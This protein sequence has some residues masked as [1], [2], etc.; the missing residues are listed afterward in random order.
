MIRWRVEA[1][2]PDGTSAKQPPHRLPRD[3]PEYHGTVVV[4]PAIDTNLPVLHWFVERPTRADTRN[5]TLAS[6]FHRGRFYDNIFCRT[7]G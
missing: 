7:R 6:V 1:T 4:D 5:G 2:A 3:S